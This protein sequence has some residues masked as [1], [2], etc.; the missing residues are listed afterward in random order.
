MG[1][2]NSFW[3]RLACNYR[4]FDGVLQRIESGTTANGIPDVYFCACAVAGWCELKARKEFPKRAT[5]IVRLSTYKETQRR[6]LA[7]AWNAG[8]NILVAVDIAGESYWFSSEE[9]LVVGTRW[10]T[11]EFKRNAYHTG[12]DGLMDYILAK[13]A[14]GQAGANSTSS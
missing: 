6:W 5:T 9:A 12:D 1:Q 3:H 14:P 8:T 2:E 13:R 4:G 11:E 7:A 10:N